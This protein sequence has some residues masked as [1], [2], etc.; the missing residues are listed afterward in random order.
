MNTEWGSRGSALGLV[1]F[2]I[3]LNDSEDGTEYTLSK[4]ADDTKLGRVADTLGLD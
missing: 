4:F 3:F 1:W 2:T